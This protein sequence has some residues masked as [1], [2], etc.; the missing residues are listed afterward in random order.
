MSTPLIR[1]VGA[2]ERLRT[3]G[4]GH[5]DANDYHLASIY[6][7]VR[8]P[9]GDFGYDYVYELV[10]TVDCNY[11]SA[12]GREALMAQSM[13]IEVSTV[14][15]VPAHTQVTAEMAIVVEDGETHEIHDL[16]VTHVEYAGRELTRTLLCI[17]R[18]EE[19]NTLPT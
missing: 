15:S 12:G 5:F 13:R 6:E 19:E 17:E 9:S 1:A 2:S 3:R 7:R 14:V 4:R 18:P 8:V 16:Q 11:W 10:D